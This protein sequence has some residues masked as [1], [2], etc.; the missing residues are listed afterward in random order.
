MPKYRLMEMPDG[1][2]R[3]KSLARD[4][5]MNEIHHLVISI[6]EFEIILDLMRDMTVVLQKALV[7][8]HNKSCW[9]D[10]GDTEGFAFIQSFKDFKNP[11]THIES[12]RYLWDIL[13]EFKEWK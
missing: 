2:K 8:T 12:C 6:T 5:S 13:E 7:D 9:G 1:Y 3:N 10:G 4:L 11:T